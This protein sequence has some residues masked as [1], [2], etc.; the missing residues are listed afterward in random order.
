MGQSSFVSTAAQTR[1]SLYEIRSQYD[2]DKNG[3]YTNAE[4]RAAID[5]M[6]GSYSA[7]QKAVLWQLA[8][9]STSAKNNPYSRKVGQQVVDA[10]AAAKEAAAQE[11]QAE[12]EDE[13]FSTALQN[14][15]MG[16]G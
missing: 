2:A 4:I 15:L 9:G 6:S 11:A 13:D 7:E 10:R 5:A 1:I 8:T 12:E 14:Q 16:R 3:S